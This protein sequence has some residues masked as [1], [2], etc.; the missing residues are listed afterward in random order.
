MII[1]GLLSAM[2]LLVLLFKFGIR[3]I[4]AYDIAID[5]AAT[6]LLMY[7]FAAMVGGLVISVTLFVMK[8]SMYRE[9]LHFVKTNNFPYRS[10]RWI[11]VNP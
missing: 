4:L 2:G 1:A 11:A 3:R 10:W 8:K 7:L 6:G 9:E 5:I